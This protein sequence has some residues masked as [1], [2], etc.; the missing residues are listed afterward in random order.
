MDFFLLSSYFLYAPQ[1]PNRVPFLPFPPIRSFNLIKIPHSQLRLRL[2]PPPN[3]HPPNRR[4]RR[5]RRLLPPIPQH[6]P[7]PFALHPRRPNRIPSQHPPGL[8]INLHRHLPAPIHPPLNPH[9]TQFRNQHR[10]PRPI[11]RSMGSPRPSSS[12]TLLDNHPRHSRPRNGRYT[13][14]DPGFVCDA[15]A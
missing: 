2:P 11:H 3:P 15:D 5:C 6:P 8:S 12:V 4:R 1:S 14:Q 10:A 9:N 7:P 13:D